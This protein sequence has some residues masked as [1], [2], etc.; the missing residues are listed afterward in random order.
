MKSI[1]EPL[2]RKLCFILHRGFVECRNLARVGNDEQAE[3]LADAFEV[4]P[5]YLLDWGDETLMLIRSHLE[6]YQNKY[7][8]D[9]FDYLAVLDMA[10]EEFMATLANY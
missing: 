10:D 6:S 4:M 3:D 2:F 5:G 1:P 7:G 9:S 8:T